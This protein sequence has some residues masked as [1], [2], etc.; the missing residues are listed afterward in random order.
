MGAFRTTMEAGLEWL[1]GWLVQLAAQTNASVER[2]GRRMI[3][4]SRMEALETTR[5]YRQIFR[6]VEI[7]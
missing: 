1:V 5:D 7:S 4:V 3:M 2:M 6:L